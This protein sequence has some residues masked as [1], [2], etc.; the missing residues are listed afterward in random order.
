MMRYYFVLSVM[1]LGAFESASACYRDPS[2]VLSQSRRAFEIFPYRNN[3]ASIVSAN[4]NRAGAFMISPKYALTSLHIDAAVAPQEREALITNSDLPFVVSKGH[5]D[6]KATFKLAKERQ[7]SHVS[8][9][10]VHYLTQHELVDNKNIPFMSVNPSSYRDRENLKE[11]LE[12]LSQALRAY[13]RNAT[14]ESL[15]SLESLRDQFPCLD[16]T[17]ILKTDFDL[18]LLELGTPLEGVETLKLHELLPRRNGIFNAFLYNKRI[19]LLKSANG[20]LINATEL[21]TLPT[22]EMVTQLTPFVVNMKVAH[23]ETSLG[24]KVVADFLSPGGEG[25]QIAMESY[26]PG[27]PQADL[28]Q[29]PLA[30]S[31]IEGFSGSPLFAQTPEGKLV[32]LGFFSSE[33]TQG[34]SELYQGLK[35]IGEEIE[36][37]SPQHLSEYNNF[38]RTKVDPLLINPV[39]LLNVFEPISPDLLVLINRRILSVEG[40]DSESFFRRLFDGSRL[41][42][43]SCLSKIDRL[44]ERRKRAVEIQSWYRRK[45]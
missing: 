7:A 8:G 24:I 37:V 35:Q 34:F 31:G 40:L 15:L 25:E 4:G 1:F 6:I 26:A 20:T 41:L 22:G 18:V 12:N 5:L 38:L 32:F 21:K 11:L 16:S 17:K 13:S 28:A 2:E 23:T 42:D 43:P 10:K 44:L 45:K 3:I 9:F 30:G 36:R 29:S 39:P 27:G 33:F 19:A 14:K